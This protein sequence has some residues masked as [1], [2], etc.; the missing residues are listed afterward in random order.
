MFGRLLRK[1]GRKGEP[2]TFDG[3]VG[4]VSARVRDER[5]RPL[6]GAEMTLRHKRSQRLS[7]VKADDFGLAVCTASAGTYGVALSAGGYRESSHLVEV[8]SG[9]HTALGDV[10]LQPDTGLRLPEPGEWTIDPDHSSIRFVARHIGLSRVHGRFTSF[11]G[12]INVG[13]RIEDSAVEVVIDAASIDT[14][15]DK[16]DEHLRSADFLDVDRFPKLHFYSDRVRQVAGDRWQFDGT[17]NLRGASRGVRLDATYLGL[18]SWNGDRLGAVATTELHR[19]DF[20]INWQ[21]TIAKG[22]VVV[23]STVEIQLDIQATRA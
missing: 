6:S 10:E 15:A 4:L 11:Q 2:V 16:R 12:R 14:A 19:E 17:L 9:D 5:G 20:T 3:G 21:Q 22:L 18:R 1:D 7:T 23:G 8:A 13:Q